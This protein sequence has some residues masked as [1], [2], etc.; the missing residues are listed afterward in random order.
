MVGTALILRAVAVLPP[1]RFRDGPG[2][3]ALLA[4][5]AFLVIQ[6]SPWAR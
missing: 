1:R 2:T 3:L 4:G 5:I 6:S